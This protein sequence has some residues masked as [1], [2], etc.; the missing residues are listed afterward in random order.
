M[1]IF[2]N[3]GF[4]TSKACL[5]FYKVGFKQAFF[6][7]NVKVKIGNISKLFSVLC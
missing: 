7:A 6:S 1:Y 3:S 5:L 4:V 2:I